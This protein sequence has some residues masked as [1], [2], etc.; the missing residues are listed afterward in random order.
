MRSTGCIYVRCG[1][2]RRHGRLLQGAD[3]LCKWS[4]SVGERHAL[5]RLY[6]RAV[7]I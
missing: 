6:L 7:R 5:D 2:D 3:S 1:Y 4:F